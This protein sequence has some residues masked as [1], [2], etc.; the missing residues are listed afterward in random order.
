V[1]VVEVGEYVVGSAFERVAEFD[2]FGQRGGH[3]VCQGVDDGF[4]GA[5]A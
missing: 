3:A 1:W 5:F 2:E 4:E